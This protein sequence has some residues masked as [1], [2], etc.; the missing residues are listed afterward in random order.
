MNIVILL[1]LQPDIGQTLLVLIS[2]SVLIFI[3]GKNIIFLLTIFF[4]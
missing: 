3:S 4:K 2:W 1:A